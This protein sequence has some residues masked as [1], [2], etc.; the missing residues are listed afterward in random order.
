MSKILSVILIILVFQFTPFVAKTQAGVSSCVTGNAQISYQNPNNRTVN[1]GTYFPQDTTSF[2]LRFTMNNNSVFTSLKDHAVRLVADGQFTPLNGVNIQNQTFD[3]PLTGNLVNKGTHNGT[4]QWFPS[5]ASNY[6][7]LCSDVIYQVGIAGACSIFGVPSKIPP[8]SPL[9]VQFLGDAETDYQLRFNDD[10]VGSTKVGKDNLG[11]FLP[12]PPVTGLD[13]DKIRVAVIPLPI[14][15][16]NRQS[17]FADITLDLKATPQPPPIAPPPPIIK[18]ECKPE[19][20]DCSSSGGTACGS[21][22]N[23]AISTAI[24]CIHTSPAVFVKDLLTF[25]IG[26]SGGL[27]FLMMLLGA[28]QMLT[29]AGNPETLNAGRERLTSAVIG[30]LFVIFAILLLQIIGAGILNIPGFKP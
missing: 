23:P 13:E 14:G 18:K 24:G 2:I 28:F 22:D 4:L 3:I 21:S 1:A 9:T 6:I 12:P 20:K 15:A 27:A 7:D 26:I 5:G 11:K 19:D 29:S 17:C 25:V 10:I 16:G 8:Y 30:L